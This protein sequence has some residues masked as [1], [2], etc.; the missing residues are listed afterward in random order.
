MR[1]PSPFRRFLPLLLLPLAAVVPLY[2]DAYRV[3]Q[4]TQIVA[5]AVA[6]TGLNLLTGFTGQVSRGH[7][8]FFGVGAY[9]T[10]VLMSQT[11]LAY[12][13]AILAGCL[14][15]LVVGLMVGLPAIRIKGLHLAI[16]TLVLAAAFPGIVRMLEPWTGGSQGIRFDRLA[17]V[18]WLPLQSDQLRFYV[19]VAALAAVVLVIAV[20]QR[21]P[22][23]RALRSLGDNEVAAV[24]YGVRATRMRVG[25]FAASACVTALGGSLFAM[26]SGFIAPGTSY[27][28]VLGSIQFLTAM[29]IGGRSLIFGPL[30]GAAVAELLP[31]QLGQESPELAHLL[32]GAILIALLL[33]A[34]NGLTGTRLRSLLP[35]SLRLP[36]PVR[37]PKGLSTTSNL[38]KQGDL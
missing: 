18:T 3:E 14:G 1:N 38:T 20:L 35:Q 31:L 33:I 25:V 11:N 7:S 9:V 19:T 12:P 17:Y 4:I 2:L 32:Y 24:A 28:T 37:L 15:G 26:S 29:V 8:A 6:V 36:S 10:A 16:V 22:T 21:R 13:L 27:V 34:P 30:I 23:G 5:V